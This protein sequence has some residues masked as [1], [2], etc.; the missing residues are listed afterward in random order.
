MLCHRFFEIHN[1]KSDTV[2]IFAKQ[3]VI[4]YPLQKPHNIS[5]PV[6][7]FAK[8]TLFMQILAPAKLNLCL[9]I[10][11]KAPSGYHEIQTVFHEHLGLT[12]KLEINETPEND[13]TSI[14]HTPSK[15]TYT[16]VI[17]M[18][19]NLAHK[20]LKLLKKT[21]KINKNAKI[22]I[23]KNIPVSSGLGGASSNAAAVLKGLNELWGLCLDQDQLLAL[24][25]ELGA[26][27]P[28]FIIGGTALGTHFGEKITPLKPIKNI[29]FQLQSFKKWPIPLFQQQK[30][31]QMYTNIDLSKCGK[32][33]SKTEALLQA[34]ED[35]DASKIIANLHNDFETLLPPQTGHLSGSGPAI[36][37]ASIKQPSL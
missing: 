36:F 33:T 28:F 11:K 1:I 5:K 3:G 25:A 37:T 13:H 7:L 12:D 9:D 24:A 27:V 29:Q 10:L 23:T 17:S 18:K 21:Y 26:D 16:P 35:E 31:P 22:T 4:D 14:A 20:A 34:I 19:E 6:N 32:N 30:T 15:N 2:F 8:N